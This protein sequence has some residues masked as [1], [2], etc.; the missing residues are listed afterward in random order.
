MIVWII[1]II[2]IFTSPVFLRK[3]VF[4]MHMSAKEQKQ[5][6]EKVRREAES[7]KKELVKAKGKIRRLT[8]KEW[9]PSGKID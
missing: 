7:A 9:P 1:K 6:E 4:D 3:K 2:F 5:S 8:E